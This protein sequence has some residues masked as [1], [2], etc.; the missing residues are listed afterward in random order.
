MIEAW[1]AIP[2]YEG[3]YEASTEGRVRRILPIKGSRKVPYYLKPLTTI[4]GY[5]RVVL[6]KG[7]IHKP[8]SIHRAVMAAFHGP[9]SHQVNH[10]N[11]DKRDNRL[12]N[13]EY[14]THEENTTH[15]MEG[16]HKPKGE[17]HGMSKLNAAQVR[18][19][20]RLR[21]LGFTTY[22]IAE[23]FGVTRPNIGSILLRK[24]WNHVD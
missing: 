6:T 20:R 14:V 2:E 12:A 3:I 16:G 13:L 21:E 10:K 15:A 24:T 18:E 9:S 11:F 23:K 7:G 5:N 8:V 19:I 1:A 4:H 17:G 22:A